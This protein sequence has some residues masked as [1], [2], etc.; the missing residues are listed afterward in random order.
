[1]RRHHKHLWRSRGFDVFKSDEVDTG[2]WIC[3]RYKF[4]QHW[5]HN[6]TLNSIIQYFY[7]VC[8]KNFKS[9][10]RRHAFLKWW[11]YTVYLTSFLNITCTS[12]KN[13]NLLKVRSLL[14]YL[15]IKLV[16]PNLREKLRRQVYLLR[17]RPCIVFSMQKNTTFVVVLLNFLIF[18]DAF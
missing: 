16:V 15:F 11:I 2:T 8:R 12:N 10:V 14:I 13:N 9:G 4:H 6:S 7:A 3:S 18:L 17:S 1:L 5:I